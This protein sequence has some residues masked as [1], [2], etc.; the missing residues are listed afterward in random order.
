L[1]KYPNNT[2]QRNKR[3]TSLNFIK[4]S[5]LSLVLV[6]NTCLPK[7]WETGDVSSAYERIERAQR[8]YLLQQQQAANQTQLQIQQQNDRINQLIAQNQ[9]LQAALHDQQP[10]ADSQVEGLPNVPGGIR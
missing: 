1:F 3:N 8:A 10:G 7:S 6:S 4:I 2:I 9:Q 5:C